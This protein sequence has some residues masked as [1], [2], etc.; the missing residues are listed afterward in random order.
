MNRAETARIERNL[1]QRG[2]AGA[3]V[4]RVGPALTLSIP[5]PATDACLA[6]LRAIWDEGDLV[7]SLAALTGSP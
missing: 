4:V 3:R 1:N 6:E 2:F 5:L 7:E